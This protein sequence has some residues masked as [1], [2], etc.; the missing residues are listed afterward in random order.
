M[1][2]NPSEIEALLR[3][4]P[5]FQPPTALREQLHRAI[6]LN[7][8]PAQ[9]SLGAG[10]SW[11]RPRWLVFVPACLT[12]FAV[13]VFAIQYF[14]VRRTK[15]RLDALKVAGSAGANPFGTASPA[16]SPEKPF[17]EENP[18]TELERLEATARQLKSQLADMNLLRQKIYQLKAELAAKDTPTPDPNDDKRKDESRQCLKNLGRLGI[19]GRMWA[20]DHNSVYPS[21]IVSMAEQIA[22]MGPDFPEGLHCPSDTTR[23]ASTDWKSFVSTS[24]S[25]EYLAANGSETDPQRVMFRCPIHGHITMSDGS[26]DA[27]IGIKHPE[28]LK[29]I[30]GRIYFY[31][32]PATK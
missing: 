16:V 29:T 27:E 7:H 17:S 24:V 11:W 23:R 21:N 19:A 9:D 4:V 12:F 10:K 14:D 26:V 30:D 3:R 13:M 28:S 22:D 31:G 32:L 18:R 1:N 2:M 20:A 15:E 6:L 8:Q 5:G 25:Y